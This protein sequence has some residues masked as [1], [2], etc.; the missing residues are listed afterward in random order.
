MSNV[1]HLFEQIIKKEGVVAHSSVAA[2]PSDIDIYVPLPALN[3]ISDILAEAGFFPILSKKHHKVYCK[4]VNKDLFLFDICSDYEHLLT[5]FP[6]IELSDSAN[7]SIGENSKLHRIVKSYFMNLTLH[8]ENLSE[9]TT[10]LRDKANFK[11]F[12]TNLSKRSYED[13]FAFVVL[14][15]MKKHRAKYRF[16]QRLKLLK[17]GFWAGKSYAMVGPDGAGK[18]FYID[19]LTKT[20]KAKVMYMGDWFFIFQAVYNLLMK[21]PSPFNRFLYIFYF[22]ENQYR[23]LIVGVNTSVGRVV[24]IDRFPGLNRPVILGGVSG[25]LN[26]LFFFLTCKPYLF[27]V[28]QANPSIVFARKQELSVRE[29]RLIQEGIITKLQNYRHI[30]INTED[31]DFNLNYLARLIYEVK[32]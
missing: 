2:H 13:N 1:Q 27:V 11:K 5:L 14:R 29:I 22:I 17:Q 23:R 21:L 31:L 18:G 30:T 8:A 15:Y 25:F 7:R 9:I 16:V 24:I 20:G 26:H 3:E 10:F 19:L 12:P 32:E 6:K 28:L 4:Y